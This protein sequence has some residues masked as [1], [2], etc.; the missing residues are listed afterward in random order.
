MRWTLHILHGALPTLGPTANMQKT[1]A[2]IYERIKF[3]HV[4]L[5][6]C[7]D[8]ISTCDAHRNNLRV[9][10]CSPWGIP[11][12]QRK[13]FQ[14]CGGI[15]LIFARGFYTSAG[16]TQRNNCWRGEGRWNLSSL[17]QVWCH[18]ILCVLAYVCVL[19][20]RVFLP[21]CI[22]FLHLTLQTSCGSHVDAAT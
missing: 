17:S 16:Y 20:M 12:R 14:Q 21:P 5:Q 10:L 1:F 11:H 22:F 18:S 15:E 7:G 13:S 2:G 19:C 3:T 8:T 9:G 4:V 6:N